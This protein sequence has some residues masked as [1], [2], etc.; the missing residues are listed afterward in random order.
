MEVWGTMTKRRPWKYEDKHALINK[1]RE[2]SLA[3][4]TRRKYEA[5][6]TIFYRWWDIFDTFG[7]EGLRSRTRHSI[8]SVRKLKKENEQLKK[9][10]TEKELVEEVLQEAYNKEGGGSPV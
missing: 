7:V 4:D 8:L 2:K 3:I 9:M 6:P 10:L 5:D 1:I